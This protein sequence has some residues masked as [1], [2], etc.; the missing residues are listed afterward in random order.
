MKQSI[1]FQLLSFLTLMVVVFPTTCWSETKPQPSVN[2]NPVSVQVH[3]EP[4]KVMAGGEAQVTVEMTVA[5]GHH[6]YKDMLKLKWANDEGI[7][8]GDFTVNPT[9][10]FID[11]VTKKSREGMENQANIRTTIKF[12][13]S[14]GIGKREGAIKVTYQACSA[15][16]CLFPKT[17]TLPFSY[18]VVDSKIT[19]TQD[20]GLVQDGFQK[21]L[22]R[23]KFWVYVFVFIGGFLTSL[24]PCIFPM[25][26]I[27]ISIIGARAAQ[28]KKS[29]AFSLSVAYVLGIGF[30]YSALGVVAATTGA[31]FGS[32]LSNI[33]VVSFI[34]LVFIAMGL[35][36]LGFFELQVPAIL[37]NKFGNAQTGTGLPGAFAA[38]LFAG[39]V[40]SPCIG[41][42]LVSI[43]T[44]VAQTADVTFGFTLLFTFA[45]GMGIL[46]IVLGTFS[47]LLTK[48]PKAGGWMESTKFI[49]GLTFI[50][51]AFYYLAPIIPS[52]FL[53]TLAGSFLLLGT[54]YYG[55]FAPASQVRAL[56]IKKGIL[57]AI[58]FFGLCLVA[59]GVLPSN[60]ITTSVTDSIQTQ[61]KTGL[62]WQNYDEKLFH[63]AKNENQPI[64]LDFTADWCVACHE[65]EA[66]TYTDATVIKE[67]E[68]FKR[69]KIDATHSDQP[70]VEELKKKYKVVG[71]PTIIFINTQGQV[72]NDIT[73]TGFVNAREFLVRMAKTINSTSK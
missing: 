39:I 33:W 48:I 56:Q 30:T 11:P 7:T 37:R 67:G 28:N 57:L 65:L 32:L 43:L 26:P 71:L 69:F 15:K 55:A 59:I 40:A 46:F 2:E 10:M 4:T 27:T 1:S 45:M 63:Q 61:K 21:A 68:V 35:S 24:T 53:Y 22:A 72:L 5:P 29:R 31:L 47:G 20:T 60:F 14:L 50:I 8:I 54:S 58:Y 70:I 19:A 34:A 3:L 52:K 38:G 49:F 12:P 6:A 25:I 41:P 42:V 62:V 23:G 17:V 64:I 73:V 51:M 44:Y 66:L 16:Y 13:K 9:H 36:M 18:E